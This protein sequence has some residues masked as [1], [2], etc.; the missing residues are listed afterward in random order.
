MPSSWVCT[1]SGE[2]AAAQHDSTNETTCL[3]RTFTDPDELTSEIRHSDIERTITQRGAFNAR[4]HRIHLHRLWLQHISETLPRVAHTYT[5]P[6]R[7]GLS[8]RTSP[9]PAI[10]RRGA[11]LSSTD[12]VIVA[13]P[14]QSFHHVLT[15]PTSY[16]G[17]HLPVDDF[18]A[19]SE[20]MLGCEPNTLKEIYKPPPG[21]MQSLQRLHAA[22][23][24]LAEDAPAVLA[25][26][27][28]AR[29]LEQALIEA[30]M[31]C[32]H[33][34]EIEENGAARRQHATIM[35]RF[36]R[37]IERSDDQAIYIPELCREVGA[38][39]RTLRMAC[40]EH[41]GMGPKRYLLLRRM[42]M[43]RCALQEANSLS[44]TVTEI[45]TR[46]GFWQFGRLAL[47]Y[48]ALFGERPSATLA[49][50]LQ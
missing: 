45:A 22:A 21:R 12:V 2:C 26:P 50:R 13:R 40:Q 34:D 11:E 18:A 27:E 10:V 20:T 8:I 30:W 32:L 31:N 25:H 7:I 28:V 41:L 3:V 24:V 19:L 49:R 38:S 44:V 5:K 14:D 33:G 39:E 47:E 16:G 36:R 9:G 15:G 1:D 37:V 48:Q 4:F 35:R 6:G 43:V 42:N 29:G 17:M 46:Y 23:C